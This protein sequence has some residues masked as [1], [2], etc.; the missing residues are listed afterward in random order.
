MNEDN[1]LSIHDLL[2]IFNISKESKILVIGDVMLDKT[3]HTVINRI[4]PEAPVPVSKV[5]NET[6]SPGGAANVAVNLASLGVETILVGVIGEDHNGETLRETLSAPGIFFQPVIET[7]SST[8]TK[9]R[10]MA[11]NQQIIRLDFEDA[12]SLPIKIDGISSYIKEADVVVLSDYGKGALA[13]CSE[14]ISFARSNGIPVIV[15][16]KGVDFSKYSGS[17]IITPNLKEFE[18]VVGSI[19]DIKDATKKAHDLI[20]SLSLE[21]LLI[22]LGARGM[23]L[24]D[25]DGISTSLAATAKAVFDVTGAGDTV[26]ALTAMG[27]LSGKEMTVSVALANIA[28]GLVVS[29]SGTASLTYPELENE[30]SHKILDR[31]PKRVSVNTLL[32]VLSIAR[33]NGEK[34]VFTNGCFDVLHVG[35]IDYLG[36][37]KSLGDLLIV[38]INSDRSIK[39]LKGAGRPYN[40]LND[41]AMLLSALACV[42]YVLDFDEDTPLDLIVKIAPDVLVKG[43]DYSLDQ[44]VGASEVIAGGGRVEA[45]E[46]LS[47]Y[48][49]T[50]LI[51]KIR[52]NL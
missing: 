34:I 10:V 14:I 45:I 21:F 51:E 2:S 18:A 25:K 19:E 52:S 46:F 15:D 5:Y 12:K 13:D 37:A 41:R 16:P 31:K 48:S 9:L 27:V 33:S 17:H 43:A 36:K 24:V 42:D 30:I 29:K 6:N 47:G 40:T 20:L 23:L 38:A 28:A 50:S 8:I 22:T 35:H 11:Q 7:D 39:N 4:S 44:I 32:D 1:M 26:V 3:Y 49:T